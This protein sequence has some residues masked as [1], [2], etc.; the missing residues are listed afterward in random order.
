MPLTTPLAHRTRTPASAHHTPARRILA[1]SSAKK[2]SAKKTPLKKPVSTTPSTSK[3]WVA[4]SDPRNPNPPKNEIIPDW[5]RIPYLLWVKIL[6][7][8]SYPL[9]DRDK[10]DWLVGASR[11]G[12]LLAEPALSVLYYRPPLLTRPMAHNL[13]ALL[14]KDPSTT[15]FNYRAKVKK[16][17]IDVG[18][19][20]AKTYRGQTLDL[21]SMVRN[22]PQLQVINF[23]HTKDLAPYRQLDENL[24]W[25]YPDSLFDA[26]NGIP[27]P[28]APMAVDVVRT[29]ITKL[30]AWR[31]NRRMLGD[32][33]FAR[34]KSLHMSPAFAGLKKLSFVN[35]QVPSLHIHGSVDD[36]EIR[37]QDTAFVRALADAISALPSL[38]YLSAETSTAVNSELLSLL[39]KTL[40]TLELVNC[41]EVSGEDL[42]EYLLTHG[43]ELEHL[44][45]Q[46]NQSLNLNFLPVLGQSCP[47]FKTLCMDFK[48][49][50]HHEF[51]SDGDPNYQEVLG[52]DEI[53]DWPASLEKLELKN[54]RQLSA[55]AAEMLFQS[56]VDSALNLPNL[57][58]IDIKTMLDIPFR[59]RS[60]LRDKWVVKLKEVFLRD[61][62]DPKPFFTLRDDATNPTNDKIP[63]GTKRKARTSRLSEGETRRSRRIA[64]QISNPPS[65]E[66]SSGRDLTPESEASSNERAFRQ[67]LC[68]TVE[69]QLDNQKP[70]ERTF[71]MEDFLDDEGS[72]DAE[73]SDWDGDVEADTGYA[74]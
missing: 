18:E 16:L 37:A 29:D 66:G 52:V 69:V 39:P 72:N 3:G 32:L 44:S 7:E 70:I 25:Q 8:A 46:H 40:K 54:M 24:R 14:A 62:A 71:G 17:D 38:T 1:P 11:T 43:R 19:I 61:Q 27:S 34:I 2:L 4:Q 10:I 33:T 26:L 21:V 6:R 73:D 12:S 56:L 48:Y 15:T 63:R 68:A 60:T 58:H 74:W 49:F 23:H 36:P 65:R 50:K 42:A 53:P 59:R 22:L 57:R 45:L 35:C 55:E 20:A 13:A 41:W 9:D 5:S 51:Y 28:A 64:T 31:W 67:G 30:A 47:K